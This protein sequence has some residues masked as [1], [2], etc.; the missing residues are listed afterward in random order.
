MSESTTTQPRT[1]DE[2]EVLEF[3]SKDWLVTAEHVDASYT[4]GKKRLVIKETTMF[5]IF[6]EE[7]VRET[8]TV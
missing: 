3:F 8:E 6:P 5:P 7:E 2:V 1:M 4:A